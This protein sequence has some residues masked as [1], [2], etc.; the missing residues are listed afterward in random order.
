VA[1]VISARVGEDLLAR[2]GGIR[3]EQTRVASLIERELTDGLAAASPIAAIAGLGHSEPSPGVVCAGF[4][5]W[6]RNT[7]RIGLR[8]LP[9]CP[10]CAAALK[11]RTYQR[12]VPPCAARLIHRGAA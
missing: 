12:E 6:A 11:G 8:K 9:L 3:G 1:E 7:S 5:C 2:V 4:G 10:A